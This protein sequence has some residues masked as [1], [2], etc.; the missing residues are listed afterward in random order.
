MFENHRKRLIQYC[1]RSELRYILNGQKLISE[2]CGQTVLPDRSL[3][4]RQ[5]LV[6]NAKIDKFK[7][8]TASNFQTMCSRQCDTSN[9]SGLLACFPRNDP[10]LKIF[11]WQVLLSLFV[12]RLL[13]KQWRGL[14]V[15]TLI[16]SRLMAVPALN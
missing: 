11:I 16:F 13:Y 12:M 2:S 15:S 4:T 6:E 1:E 9:F 14:L 8:D 3:L 7:C 5:K 10:I